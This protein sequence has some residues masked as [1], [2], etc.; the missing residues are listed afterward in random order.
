M[1]GPPSNI[2]SVTTPGIL[3]GQPTGVALSGITPQAMTVTWNAVTGSG[4]I[5]YK[6]QFKKTGATVWND[7]G[8]AIGSTTSVIVPTTGTFSTIVSGL[9]Y[10]T[11][12]DWQVIAI[13]NVG[14]GTPSIV[15]TAPTTST[16][17]AGGSLIDSQG[18]TWTIAGGVA[19]LNGVSP[20]FSANVT[21]LALINGV[22]WQTNASNQ[23]YFYTPSTATTGTWNAG[24][25]NYTNPY[26]VPG[27]I[28]SVT[29]GTV[30]DTTIALSW[31]APA[32]GTAGG[33]TLIYHTQYRKL[34]T[35]AWY[36]GPTTTTLSAVIS[37][38]IPTSAQGATTLN[39]YQVQV[40]AS[41]VLGNGAALLAPT[42]TMALP[43]TNPTL[44]Y[45][46]LNCIQ[47]NMTNAG[48]AA[49]K[50]AIPN[51]NTVVIPITCT[52]TNATT[53]DVVLQN[54][55][56]TYGSWIAAATASGYQVFLAVSFTSNDGTPPVSF[57][58]TSLVNLQTWFNNLQAV[59]TG[60][61]AWRYYPRMH[62][63]VVRY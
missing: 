62:R 9:Q 15:V 52:G 34:G 24:T 10:N 28:P 53:T 35:T 47:G 7:A 33:A 22:I 44:T 56:S 21:G 51:S 58:A 40:F 43:A 26:V 17:A 38:L 54:P 60:R 55:I 48:F 57:T 20:A 36:N 13:N 4:V 29:I 50:A 25:P 41:N 5:A 32:T 18:N 27:A 19:L 30:T 42:V 45:R 3:P 16:V 59:C 23:T 39:Q 63:H 37:G 11:S 14:S 6:V 46:G 1:S 49:L 31:T 61:P 12:Y 8:P 2:L